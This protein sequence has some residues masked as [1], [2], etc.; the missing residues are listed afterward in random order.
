M[1]IAFASSEALPF[2]KTGGL[3]DVAYA[4]PKAY[5]NLG[6]EVNVYLPLYKSIASKYHEDMTYETS[7]NI[8]HGIF[9]THINLFSLKHE[10]INYYFIEHHDLFERDNLYGYVDD[11]LRFAVFQLAILESF[12][13]LKNVPEVLH[14]NDWQCGMLATLCYQRYG[15]DQYYQSIK[16]V[17]TIHNLAFQGNFPSSVLTDCLGLPYNLFSDGYLRYGDGISYLK[18]GIMDCDLLTTVSPSYALEIQTPQFGEGLQDVIKANNH[19]LYGILNGI[20]LVS[21]DPKHDTYLDSPLT[22]YEDKARFKIK[23]Q[24]YCNLIPTK[25]TL[26]VSIV[27]RLADQKGIKLILDNIDTLMHQDIQL[28]VL[29]SGEK[30]YEDHLSYLQ[31]KY[32]GRFYF[33]RGYNEGLARLIYA[34][35]DLFLMPSKF[36]PCG[37]SQMIAMRYST[38][39]YA[40]EVGG[41]KDTIFSHDYHDHVANGFTFTHFDNYRFVEGFKGCVYNFYHNPEH[42]QYLV[43]NCSKLNLSF[44]KSAKQYLVLYHQ[45]TNTY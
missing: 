8:H 21:F 11:G 18:A 23:L 40:N 30:H 13:Y 17:L 36:E 28:V 26:L 7:F 19:K 42:W 41:L 34:G 38:L 4:L 45:L 20:D 31:T 1:R 10:G 22:S 27:S 9:D 15:W 33:Y 29:G 5:V 3:A 39:V 25:Q 12:A 14:A 43:H 44:N 37:L 24:K 32:P 16:H 35:S 2:I 6:H